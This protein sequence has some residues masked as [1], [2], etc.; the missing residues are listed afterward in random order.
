MVGDY[1]WVVSRLDLVV[2]RCAQRVP[3]SGRI[4]ELEAA[5]MAG[6]WREVY[7]QHVVAVGPCAHGVSSG[8]V[9]S[10]DVPLPAGLMIRIRPPRASIRSLSPTSPEPFPAS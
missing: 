10:N 8:I 4:G 5:C 7:A 3:Y 1:R 9:T 2:A 6:R